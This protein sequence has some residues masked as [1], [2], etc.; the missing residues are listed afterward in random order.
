MPQ[1]TVR[2]PSLCA[3]PA[4]EQLYGQFDCTT[5]AADPVHR[6]RR[7]RS[8]ADREVAGFCAAALAF[9]RVA[10][11]LNSVDAVLDAM[12]ESPAAFIRRFEPDRDAVG[13]KSLAHRWTHGIDLIALAYI[14]RRMLEHAGTIEGFF[15]E[16]YRTEADDVGEALE[17]FCTRALAFDL[18]H[19]YAT[20]ERHGV[21]Y[22]FP[23]PSGGSACKRLNLFLRWMVRQ[24]HV[25][26][27]VWRRVDSSKLI[28]PLDTHVMR[29][30]QC[31]G[32]TR[33]R[34]PGWRMAHE[35]TVSLRAFDSKDPVKYDFSLCHL[36]MQNACGFNRRQRDSKCPL[37][38]WCRPG[39]RRLQRSHRPFARR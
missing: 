34:S 24:D 36:S 17:S 35:I 27:G 5:S 9:G 4:L 33:Y 10:S 8:R 11:I 14:L 32:L 18:G 22:F 6:V 23:R 21:A 31:L 37:R 30:G 3:K 26:L 19:I 2:S 12:G 1:S 25:D 16:G 7:Y 39:G 28:V 13:L 15:L 38:G 20:H 29:V